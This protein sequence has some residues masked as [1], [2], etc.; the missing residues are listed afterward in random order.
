MSLDRV[1]EPES[2]Y[3]FAVAPRFS[4]SQPFAARLERNG[5]VESAKGGFHPRDDWRGLDEA[6][7]AS[8]V[9]EIP[10]RDAVLSP[11]HLGLA[12]LPE[13]LRLAW[14]A[15][16]EKSGV[17]PTSA[18]GFERAFSDLVEFLRF[19]RL[20][21][22]ERVSLEVAVSVPGLPSTRVGSDGALQGLGFGER[23]PASDTPGRQALAIFNLGDEAS[24]VTLLELPPATL[25]KRLEGTGAASA[26]G[27]SPSELVRRYFEAVP[28]QRLLRLRLDPGEGLWLSPFGVVHDG[29]THGK[30][31]LDVML[32]VGCE[33]P[34]PDHALSGARSPNQAGAAG[35]D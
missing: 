28:E 3:R 23:A 17:S 15:Q 10:G 5:G 14:W 19:K 2:S 33:I 29:W 8:L 6:E 25:A 18:R 30:R 21:L 13:R 12:Q 4:L 9:T 1:T 26:R 24:Y 16:A 7:L 27:L 32:S 35:G 11:A 34:A 31:D 22:P 20:P